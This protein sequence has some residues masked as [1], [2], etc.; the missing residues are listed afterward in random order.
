MAFLKRQSDD[1]VEQRRYQV[2]RVEGEGVTKK[3]GSM[4]KYFGVINCGSGSTDLCIC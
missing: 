4:K 1:N 3:K 2:L